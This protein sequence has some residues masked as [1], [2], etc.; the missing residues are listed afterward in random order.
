MISGYQNFILTVLNIEIAKENRYE[1]RE[2]ALKEFF[3]ENAHILINQLSKVT[4]QS[5]LI[6]W[7]NIAIY[8]FWKN[9]PIQ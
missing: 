5:K 2:K 8:R 9:T 6:L 3:S 7:E 4:K 1:W